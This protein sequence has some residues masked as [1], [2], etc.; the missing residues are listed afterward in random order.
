MR[1]LLTGLLLLLLFLLSSCDAGPPPSRG[2]SVA[3][4]LSGTDTTGFKRADTI[5]PFQFPADH[6]AHP[7]YRNEWWYFTGVLTAATGQRFGYQVTFFRIGL[8]PPATAP[9]L[10]SRWNRHTVWMAHIALTDID[11]Q[12]H[13]FAEKLARDGVGHAGVSRTATEQAP[14][15]VWLDN[16]QLT[17]S[18]QGDGSRSPWQLA[19]A[20]DKFAL[21]LQLTPA[22][23][24][25]LQGDRGLSRKSPTPG[26][27]SYYYS[28]P[29]LHSQ[30]SVTL[31]GRAYTVAGL[32]WLDREWS[33]SALDQDQ[34][35][36]D[37]F[38]LQFNDGNDLM[39]Y[40]LRKTDGGTH[41]NSQGKW[42]DSSGAAHSVLPK[43]IELESLD[44]YQAP[45]GQH[46]PIAWR[47]RYR[48]QQWTIAALVK[49]Q[50]MDTT[51]KYWEGAVEVIDHNSQE[52]I[53]HG[54]LE[55]T[56]Y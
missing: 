45:N 42:I 8:S 49:N 7:G 12:Q 32:S 1:A 21:Q 4:A 28:I 14:L 18:H 39:Y 36:W 53:G 51:V 29:R 13:Y 26:N 44:F 23:P 48:Q 9:A 50:L 38:S 56:G 34:R 22:K 41:P 55:M 27:A 11:G 15:S 46:Y 19:V 54:Y 3:E 40:Q 52:T 30:G 33:T 16:W 17:Y 24:I 37:W 6:G 5:K 2:L 31:H 47:M 20:S 10:S 25:V 43:D 35:G